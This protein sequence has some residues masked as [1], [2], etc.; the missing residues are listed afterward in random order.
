MSK[1]P[2]HYQTPFPLAKEATE[3]YL[4]TRDHVSVSEFDGP[5]IL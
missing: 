2:F 3:Y 1:K 5:S 4:L